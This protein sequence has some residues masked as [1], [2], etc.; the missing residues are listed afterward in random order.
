MFGLG[1]AKFLQFWKQ[2]C[3]NTA[4]PKHLNYQP[5]VNALLLSWWILLGLKEQLEVCLTCSGLLA[6]I[7]MLLLF[8]KLRCFNNKTILGL[9]ILFCSIILMFDDSYSDILLLFWSTFQFWK[10][11]ENPIKY[12]GRSWQSSF[13]SEDCCDSVMG[14][15]W[16]VR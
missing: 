3:K 13:K 2:H 16:A 7:Q 10:F 4:S 6:G 8:Q 9:Y 5:F 15:T 11:L 1:D 14:C 12:S